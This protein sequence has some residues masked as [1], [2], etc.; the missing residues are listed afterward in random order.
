[1]KVMV[2]IERMGAQE[3]NRGKNARMRARRAHGDAS[4][5]RSDSA[6]TPQLLGGKN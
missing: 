4:G 1:M 6:A 2:G 3:P 5:R